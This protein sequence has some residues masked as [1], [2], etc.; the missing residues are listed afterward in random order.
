MGSPYEVSELGKGFWAV[1]ED[2][3]RFFLI[4]GSNKAMLIDTGLGGGNLVELVKNLTDKPVIIVNTHADGDHIGGNGFFESIHMHPSE[5]DYYLFGKQERNS[6][7]IPLWEGDV[8]DLGGRKFEVILIPGHTPGSIALLD[9]ENRFLFAGDSLQREL[10]YMIGRGRNLP[11]FGE[12]L[13]KL[14]KLIPAFDTVYAFH[15]HAVAEG[16]ELVRD[17]ADAYERL[18]AGQVKGVLTDDPMKAKIYDCGVTRFL[19]E[20]D[21]EL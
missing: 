19:T 18:M 7:L 2:F 1:K 17:V 9:R 12:T 8:I 5:Y 10:I 20:P 13:K 6:K 3:V 16:P 15:G 11:A 21:C 4:E 14:L